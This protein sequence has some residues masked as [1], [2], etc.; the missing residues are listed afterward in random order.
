MIGLIIFLLV[1]GLMNHYIYRR[2]SLGFEFPAGHK[3]TL[4]LIL[5]LAGGLYF[6]AH[7]VQFV[8]SIDVYYLHYAGVL[9]LYGIIFLFGLSFLETGLSMVFPEKKRWWMIGTL[10]LFAPVIFHL[11]NLIPYGE[12]IPGFHEI[13]SKMIQAVAFFLTYFIL[14]KIIAGTLKLPVKKRGG[15]I[16]VFSIG[17]ILKA[18]WFETGGI[19]GEIGGI[20]FLIGLIA[21]VFARV[22]TGLDLSKR[23]KVIMLTFFCA[24]FCVFLPRVFPWGH[25]M[26]IHGLYYIAGLWFGFIAFAITLFI[27][28]SGVAVFYPSHS[29]LRVIIVLTILALAYGYAVYNGSRV[30]VVKELTIPIK[31]LPKNMSGFTIIQLTDLHLGDIVSP[32]WL[33]KTVEKTNRLKPD[34]IVITGDLCDTANFEKYID[35]LGKLKA[36]FG[37]IAVTGNHDEE[38]IDTFLGIAGRTGMRVLRNQSVTVAG[39]IQV[40]GIDDPTFHGGDS[41]PDLKAAMKKVDPGKPVILLSHQ[42]DVFDEALQMGVDLQLS[43]HTHAGQVPPWNI[44]VSLRYQY[45]YGLYR[46]GD[47]YIYTSSGTGLYQLPMRLMSNNEIVRITLVRENTEQARMP[48]NQSI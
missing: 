17:A 47:S 45:P 27:L 44:V 46:R 4:K 19:P 18:M 30:P 16:A 37:I 31:T 24:G 9:W 3:A 22:S 6:T 14:Y 48:H 29:R 39:G 33:R 15:L 43:G 21:V 36:K 25:E 11:S 12:K 34:L 26:D 28:E 13:S 1:F 10:V 20:V 41:M 42:P 2:I 32:G 35:S 5:I 38:G 23:K 40:V 7:F 8:F